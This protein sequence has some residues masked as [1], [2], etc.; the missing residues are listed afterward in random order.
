M[1]RFKTFHIGQIEM[2]SIHFN[3][4]IYILLD[5]NFHKIFFEMDI[6]IEYL[7]F[8]LKIGINWRTAVIFVYS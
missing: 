8:T 1:S 2:L 6:P 5:V 3:I 7:R 4:L